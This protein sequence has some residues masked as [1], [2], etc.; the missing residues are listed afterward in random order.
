MSDQLQHK[1]INVRIKDR[2]PYTVEITPDTMFCTL[3]VSKLGKFT[4]S[5]RYT[6]YIKLDDRRYCLLVGSDYY[7]NC[8]GDF[9][10]N[11]P[12]GQC[13][14]TGTPIYAQV[15]EIGVY[16]TVSRHL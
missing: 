14:L 9:I 13:S 3:M 2:E 11:S 15:T 16:A 10:P 12:I 5:T 7:K 1:S 8:N 4:H 6:P